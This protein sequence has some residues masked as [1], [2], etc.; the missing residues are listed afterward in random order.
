[1][2]VEGAAAKALDGSEDVV[3]GLDARHARSSRTGRYP[4]APV[5]APF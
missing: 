1:M 3:C 4:N 2:N 5:T